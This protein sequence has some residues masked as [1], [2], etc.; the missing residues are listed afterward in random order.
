[1]PDKPYHI[2]LS[3]AEDRFR[4]DESH[5]GLGPGPCDST[6][7]FKVLGKRSIK[8]TAVE[9]ARMSGALSH[10]EMILTGKA[11]VLS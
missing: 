9:A 1:M 4:G 10:L 8:F 5:Q 7:N 2:P 6:N 3:E 11:P